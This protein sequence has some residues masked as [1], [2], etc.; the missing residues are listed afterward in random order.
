[1]QVLRKN[2]ATRGLVIG[3]VGGDGIGGIVIAVSL[4]YL[5]KKLK[6]KFN[7]NKF[8][9]PFTLLQLLFNVITD[10]L[11]IQIY[12]DRQQKEF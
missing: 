11:W 8:K 3:S 9:F 2:V 10:L 1:M 7:S 6:L 5:S 4:K 12:N